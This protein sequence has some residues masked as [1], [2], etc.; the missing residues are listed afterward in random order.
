MGS[1][2]S[3]CPGL[4]GT[5]CGAF[6]AV[7]GT[8]SFVGFRGPLGSRTGGG[9]WPGS[10]IGSFDDADLL[11]L[12]ITLNVFIVFRFQLVVARNMP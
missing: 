4:A 10:L 9:V 1:V 8:G 11:L 5:S 6:G 12:D 7:P 2:R 3:G